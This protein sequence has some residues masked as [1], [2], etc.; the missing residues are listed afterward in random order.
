MTKCIL[1]LAFQYFFW[2]NSVTV[3]GHF[4]V[5]LISRRWWLPIYWL[6]RHL[7]HHRNFQTNESGVCN[8]VLAWTLWSSKVPFIKYGAWWKR[9]WGPV[10]KVRCKFKRLYLLLFICNHLFLSPGNITERCFLGFF[11]SWWMCN[12]AAQLPVPLCQHYWGI[13]LQMSAWIHSAPYS[14]HW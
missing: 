12:K 10:C 3:Q 2:S 5:C 7:L 8:S 11:R 4:S 13:H 1:L 14:L 9:N 6:S